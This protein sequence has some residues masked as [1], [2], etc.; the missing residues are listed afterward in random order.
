VLA[1]ALP[2]EEI[3]VKG[4][5]SSVLLEGEV[6]SPSVAAIAERLAERMAPDAVISRLHARASQVRLDVK[7]LEVS[8]VGLREIDT[9]LSLRNGPDLGVAIGGPALGIDTP[10]G[11]AAV[12][13]DAGRLRL[14]AAVRALESRGELRVV[15]EPSLVALSGEVATFRAGGELPF[16]MPNDGKVTIAFKPYGAG[17]TFQPVVQENGL[18]RIG[19]D[20]ELSEIDPS[21]GLRVA[22][23]NVPG[24]KVRRAATVVELR[25]GE[26]FV[27]AGLLEQS[28]ERVGREPPF[29]A[30]I[31]VIGPALAPLIQSARKKDV[32]RELAIVVTPRLG[33]QVSSPLSE[34]GLF[35]EARPPAAPP[36]DA[37]HTPKSASAP[38]GPPLRALAADVRDALRPPLRW[39]AHAA[40]RFTAAFLG[41]A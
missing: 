23:F 38:R 34:Q 28:T 40:S 8:K 17:M 32:R 7:I 37:P 29:L 36:L 24:L 9:A 31:P 14:D 18:I 11:M 33:S 3:T 21:A 39:M 13:I 1:E 4:L 25:D 30:R 12:S 6:S 19:V 41:R 20:A 10:H 26:P 22:N 15:A 5:S 35:A 2:G 27:I 16:P